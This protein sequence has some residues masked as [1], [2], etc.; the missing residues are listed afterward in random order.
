M[1]NVT[2]TEKAF[3]TYLDVQDND[4]NT[5]KKLN[6]LLRDIRRHPTTGIGQVER[7]KGEGGNEYSRRISQKD[8]IVYTVEAD[9][10]AKIRQI[11]GHYED[12]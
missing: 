2:F 1:P 9:G 7:M 5:L 10:S 12:K 11:M 8:R 4:K 6:A 3:D